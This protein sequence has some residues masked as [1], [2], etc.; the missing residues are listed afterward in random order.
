MH[1]DHITDSEKAPPARLAGARPDLR[2]RLL[3]IVIGLVG[4]A[5][6]VGVVGIV[7]I[8]EV[9]STYNR[10]VEREASLVKDVL[11]MK[12]ALADQVIGVRGHLISRGAGRFLDPYHAGS[13]TFERELAD[14]RTKELDA[15]D[16]ALLDRVETNYRRLR[17]IY[18]REISLVQ[19]DRIPEAVALVNGSG[20]TLKDEAVAA[21]NKLYR[22]E[23]GELYAHAASSEAT[24]DRAAIGL[25]VLVG[26][27]SLLGGVLAFLVWRMATAMLRAAVEN[28][29]LAS[30]DALTG[31]ANH[32]TFHERLAE[33]FA[34]ARRHDRDLS[35]AV[36]DLDHFKNVNDLHGHPV[37]DEVLKETADRL[38]GQ[39][40]QGD[41]VA[42]IGGEEFAWLMP[43]TDP[44]DAREVAERARALVSSRPYPGVGTMTA[45]AGICDMQWAENP[46]D[47]YRLADGA[48]YWA[49][50]HG[51][52]QSVVYSPDVVK[53]LSLEDHARR[54]E[55]ER[56]VTAIVALARAVDA[57]DPRT[58]RH[59]EQVAQVAGEL[60]MA[61]GWSRDRVARLREAAQV[62]DVGKVGVPDAILFKESALTDIERRQLE[63]H[64]ALSAQI[65]AD[66]LDA[67]QVAWVRGHHER[68]DGTGYPDGLA[69]HAIPEGARILA[70]ADAWDAMTTPRAY[71]PVFAVGDALEEFRQFSGS[72]FCPDA[73]AALHDLQPR[74]GDAVSEVIGQPDS[75]IAGQPIQSGELSGPAV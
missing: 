21:L 13:L 24:A 72:Q 14:A 16:T 12:S 71:G 19:Q 62:H 46:G 66:A 33:E 22:H 1:E 45:S 63:A 67:E 47:L 29:E 3:G 27:A 69:R 34:R 2:G 75:P 39:A 38:R 74:A 26:A 6:A 68:F 9:D 10:V 32:R 30:V 28:R 11:E 23:E 61:M 5:A 57:R 53:E 25:A 37:G 4:L 55:R 52:D 73:V 40:R 8:R 51:R 64:A 59:S 7:Q 54:V 41:V 48:L 49:K 18:E 60:A 58:S 20:T 43:E 15:E 17:P 56:A 36:F 65:V 70:V 50:G 31:L 42:R 44:S 35:L